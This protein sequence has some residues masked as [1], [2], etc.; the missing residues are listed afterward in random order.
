MEANQ[1]YIDMQESL[2]AEKFSKN[3]KAMDLH[4]VAKNIAF[5]VHIA[6]SFDLTDSPPSAKLIYDFDR[7][8][9]QK[10]VE[11]LKSIPLEHT[12]HVDESGLKAAVEAKISVLSSQHEG[13]YFRIK[14][15]V[16]DPI[17]QETLEAYTQPI[18][19]ISKRNQVKKIIERKQPKIVESLSPSPSTPILPSPLKRPATDSNITETL[20]RLEEQQKEQKKMLE[21]LLSQRQELNPIKNRVTI[22]DPDDM[23]FEA[24][25]STF[26]NYYS[27]IP[28]EERA[29]KIRRVLKKSG[30]NAVENLA[31][32]V[33][34]YSGG[35]STQLSPSS[36]GTSNCTDKSCQCQECPHKKQLSR[37]DEFYD[38][39]LAEPLSPNE[40]S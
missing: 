23:D 29:N 24:A 4:I 7:V 25:F 9:D 22:P 30:D 14:F 39:F 28:Q 12:A 37:L 19:V 32:F 13:A 38:A 3:G 11:A 20:A 8:D 17:S 16:V 6:A 26:L 33:G 5:V 40:I 31:E 21:Q 35:S 18:K 2:L 34:L 27:K 36:D 10:E 15:T 1:F